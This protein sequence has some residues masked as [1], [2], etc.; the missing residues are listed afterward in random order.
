MTTPLGRIERPEAERFRK[1]RKL[2]LVPLF[3]PVPD[4]PAD[5]LEKLEQYWAGVREHHIPP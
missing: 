2:Y 3:L 5:L 4:A 1:G